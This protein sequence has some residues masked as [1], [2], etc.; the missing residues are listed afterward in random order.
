MGNDT[1]QAINSDLSNPDR[2]PRASFSS[3]FKLNGRV[4]RLEYFWILLISS[5]LSYA[6]SF[7]I[8]SLGDELLLSVFLTLPLGLIALVA[9]VKRCHDLEISEWWL[10]LVFV[11]LINV[12]FGLYLLLRK[13]T[14]SANKYGPSLRKS[15]TA[16]SDETQW[17][18][19]HTESRLQQ[20]QTESLAAP[21]KAPQNPD[22]VKEKFPAEP[23]QTESSSH[24]NS[25]IG[26]I[27]ISVIA[28]IVLVPL[29]IYFSPKDSPSISTR[30]LPP[31]V[32][33]STKIESEDAGP[34]KP[35]Q[36]ASQAVPTAQ[37]SQTP[38]TKRMSGQTSFPGLDAISTDFSNVRPGASAPQQPTTTSDRVTIEK[39][40]GI[41][42]LWA[43][44][45]PLEM[46]NRSG[47]KIMLGN[48][49]CQSSINSDANH[50]T[51]NAYTYDEM[52]NARHG[53]WNIVV[54]MAH[55][56]WDAGG[57]SMFPMANFKPSDGR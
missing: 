49:V 32:V 2:N 18:T 46:P 6:I 27:G 19:K 55:I 54:N 31:D 53:C 50:R 21:L 48:I 16:D 8:K 57:E 33:A 39:L 22:D 15:A 36:E 28:V 11:P 7:F 43:P 40:H 1:Q 42:P 37:S 24:S 35:P 10:L 4:G 23:H 29:I 14:G 45:S 9:A 52:G 34:N 51:M 12:V 17:A 13:G 47:G 41:L 20:P 25:G 44:P 30:P 26:A 56:R 3:L 5:L 38:P